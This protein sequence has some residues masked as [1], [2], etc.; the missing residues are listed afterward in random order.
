[1]RTLITN[2]ALFA[3]IGLMARPS[4]MQMTHAEQPVAI[5]ADVPAIVFKSHAK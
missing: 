1:M 5:A 3:I 2:L 4:C